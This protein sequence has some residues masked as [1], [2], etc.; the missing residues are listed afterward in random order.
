MKSK[1]SRQSLQKPVQNWKIIRRTIVYKNVCLKFLRPLL[2]FIVD[3]ETLLYFLKG[4]PG[5][6]LLFRDFNIDTLK[7]DLDKKSMWLSWKHMILR[8]KTNYR[9]GSRLLLRVALIT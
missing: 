1:N 5:E 7:D 3:L 8:Y 9:Q 4:L 6:T 2:K